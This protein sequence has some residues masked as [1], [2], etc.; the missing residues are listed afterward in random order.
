MRPRQALS[1]CKGTEC[2]YNTVVVDIG[3]TGSVGCVA[4]VKVRPSLDSSGS[5][6][7]A[8]VGKMYLMV[9]VHLAAECD[10]RLQMMHEVNDGL[11]FPYYSL[12][13]RPS[14]HP[15][16]AVLLSCKRSVLQAI[17]NWMVGKA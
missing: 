5:V 7:Q 15:V 1:L 12:V 10:I 4:Q 6:S 11:M 16:F 3:P 8:L 17:K 9:R 2:A 13:P 14:H